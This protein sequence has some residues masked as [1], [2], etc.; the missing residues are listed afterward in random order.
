MKTLIMV[1][2]VVFGMVSPPIVAHQE[3][4]GSG[5]NST[6]MFIVADDGSL[7]LLNMAMESVV[8]TLAQP[9]TVLPDVVAQTFQTE[10]FGSLHYL[11]DG[12]VVV[13]SRTWTMDENGGT[14]GL[15]VPGIP[16]TKASFW[17]YGQEGSLRMIADK[18]EGFRANVGIINVTSI[19]VEVSLEVFTADGN[20][21]PGESSLT[22]TLQP[23]DMV[24]KL[25]LFSGIE[26]QNYEGLIVRVSPLTEG[27][28]IMAYLTLVDNQTNDASYQEAF[29]FGF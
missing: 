21:A 28:A 15:T 19:P 1:I 16:I 10:G 27:G 18:K 6:G 25:D 14:F 2:T 29:R 23:Y 17:G 12:P 26:S 3:M 9:V 13:M 7:L 4:K 8:I 22:L 20:P 24:Q 11:A 5:M